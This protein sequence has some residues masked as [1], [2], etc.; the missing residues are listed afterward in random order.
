MLRA[1]YLFHGSYLLLLFILRWNQYIFYPSWLWTGLGIIVLIGC[2]RDWYRWLSPIILGI[3]LALLSVQLATHIP[4]PGTIDWYADNTYQTV[5]GTIVEDPDKRPLQT[6]YTIAVSSR[7]GS[8]IPLQGRI[9]VNDKRQWP[10]FKRGDKITVAGKLERPGQIEAFHYDKYLSRFNIYAVMY[11]GSLEKIGEESTLI[12]IFFNSLYT[13]KERFEW[14]INRLYAEPHAS[15][16]AGLLTGSRKGIPEHLMEDFNTTGLTHIIAISG[17]NIAIVIILIGAIFGFVPKRYR[18]IPIVVCIILFTLFVGASSAVVRAAIMGCLSLLALQMGREN[19][20]MITLLWTAFFMTTLNPKLLWYDAGFQL[21]FLAVVG[22][23]EFSPMLEKLFHRV[24]NAFAIRESLTMTMAAQLVA[25]PLIIILFGRLSLVAPLANILV[26]P[27]IPLAMLFGFVGTVLSSFW[28]LG[29][30]LIAYLGWAC[31]ELII[32]ITKTLAQVPYASVE[33]GDVGWVVV[34]VYY[35]ILLFWKK[36]A[37]VAKV[38]E[39]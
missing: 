13:V 25:V 27:L 20:V 19:T 16:M 38:A 11:R 8:Q 24:P 29:G 35:V 33:V 22:L 15:F 7:S 5:H 14:Q 26:A 4:S 23:L 30:Q 37:Y 21:S 12:T 34:I 10:E 31:L 36:V 39:V 9:L 6:K 3:A 32:I 2:Y 1:L 17:Y 18:I 28:W